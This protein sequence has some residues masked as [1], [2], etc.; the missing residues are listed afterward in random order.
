MLRGGDV[1]NH[2]ARVLGW[3]TKGD[4]CFTLIQIF[5]RECDQHI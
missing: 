1:G 2:G 4:L 3:K 5:A